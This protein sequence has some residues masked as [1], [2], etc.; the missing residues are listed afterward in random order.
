MLKKL[1]KNDTKIVIATGRSYPS[2]MNQ[3]SK[4]PI[5]YDY[6][7]AADGSIIY[8][9]NGNILKLY[10][11]NEEIIE[12]FKKYYQEINLLNQ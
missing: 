7:I 8:D 1:Q 12:P 2:I 3:L 4:Y 11:M 9:T 10:E 6:I 5:P